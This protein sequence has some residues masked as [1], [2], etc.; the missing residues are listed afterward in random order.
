MPL[1]AHLS[2]RITDILSATRSAAIYVFG[3]QGTPAARP[4][5]DLDLAILP[6]RPLDPLERFRLSNALSEA[7]GRQV[8]LIDLTRASTVMA[9]EVIRTGTLIA[10]SDPARRHEFEMRTLADYARLNE[11]RRE[12]LPST[13]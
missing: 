11:E 2:R 9:K 10:E 5:S 12:S 8:D 13:R 6:P 4:D 7:A 3:S 1:P